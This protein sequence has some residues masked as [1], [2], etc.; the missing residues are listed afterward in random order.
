LDGIF[1]GYVKMGDG[2]RI[3]RLC[4]D[5]ETVARALQEFLAETPG[6]LVMEDGLAAFDLAT[7]RYSVSSEH[8]KCLLH[9]WSSENNMVRRVLDAERKRDVLKLTVQRFGKARP[10]ILE[11]CSSAGRRSPT[12]RK[13]ARM[14]YAQLLKTVIERQFAGFTLDKFSTA[15]DLERSFSPV[16]T[17]A[18][19]RRGGSARALM[20]VNAQEAQSSIDGAL[21]FGLLWLDYCRSHENRAHVEG[22]TLFLPPETSA[23]VRERMAHLDS[24]AARWQL[25]E[26]E[27]RDACVR[28][29]DCSDRGN[30][31]TR[32]IH[33]PDPAAARE[34]F[35]GS[36]ERVHNLLP[37]AEIAVL[38]SSE[39]GFRLNGLE[40]ARARMTPDPATFRY[41]EELVYGTGAAEYQLHDEA[42]WSR[43]RDLINQLRTVRCAGGP[44]ADPLWRVAPERWLESIVVRDV[45]VVDGHLDPAWAYSQ[46]PAFSASDRAMIDVLSLTREGRLALLELKAS[47]DIHLVLQGLDYWARVVW[48][49]QRGEFQRFG[50]FPGRE[51]S[52]AKPLLLLV[53]PAFEV[54]PATDTLLRYLS[55]EIEYELAGIGQHWRD[56]V[57]VVFRKR[58]ENLMAAKV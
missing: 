16:Y 23:V 6:A 48:H 50:Y 34:R 47:E 21:T 33:F 39:I 53:A 8:S 51:I 18:L 5:A 27:E 58:R 32:L 11:V 14:A 54:H 31:A 9:L 29:L 36:I 30:I 12:A 57:R 1:S 55:P 7:A 49:Q 25:Y 43:F 26:L 2:F 15:M 17:R 45:S 41:Q 22:L 19:V 38:S 37:E 52:E 10:S 4:M 24:S 40:F 35:A 3:I 44:H 46:V 56:G 42:A 28:E 20:G 13:R